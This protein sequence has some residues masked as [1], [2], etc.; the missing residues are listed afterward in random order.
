MALHLNTDA[1][2]YALVALSSPFW[3]P[4]AKALLKE[5]NDALRDEGGLLGRAPT[6]AELQKLEAAHGKFESPM[7]SERWEDA[8]RRQSSAR[9]APRT[10]R[11]AG[12]TVRRGFRTTR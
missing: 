11:R 4:F 6:K 3:L 8:R 10:A 1:V 12:G 5:F 7:L 9:G 2:K